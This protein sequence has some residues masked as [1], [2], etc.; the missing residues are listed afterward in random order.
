MGK[1]YTNFNWYIES[2]SEDTCKIAEIKISA[3]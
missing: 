3:I 2:G 1:M